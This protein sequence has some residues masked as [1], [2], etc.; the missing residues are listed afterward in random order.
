MLKPLVILSHMLKVTL[1]YIIVTLPLKTSCA[2]GLCFILNEFDAVPCLSPEGLDVFW[3]VRGT[4]CIMT[5][6]GGVLTLIHDH[7]L[8]KSAINGFHANISKRSI[9]K[10]TL[11]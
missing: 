8:C 11:R 7:L 5:A 3:Y 9:A 10:P 2:G 1:T 6:P 4:V